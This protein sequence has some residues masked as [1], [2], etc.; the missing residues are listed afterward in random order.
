[1]TDD[2]DERHIRARPPYMAIWE[3]KAWAWGVAI[4]IAGLAAI[5]WAWWGKS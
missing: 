5:A 4:G 1:M 2:F 3:L